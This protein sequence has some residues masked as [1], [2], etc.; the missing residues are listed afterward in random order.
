MCVYIS[1]WKEPLGLLVSVVT[2]AMMDL[3]LRVVVI[4]R[5]RLVLGRDL[6]SSNNTAL[7]LLCSII[8]KSNRS[9]DK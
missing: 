8:S 4:G 9:T 3:L 5:L 2:V 6:I 1:S 7:G